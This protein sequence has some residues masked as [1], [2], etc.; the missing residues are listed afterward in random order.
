MCP[1]IATLLRVPVDDASAPSEAPKPV[2]ELLDELQQE[3]EQRRVELRE[4]AAL[5]PAAMSRRAILRAVAADFRHAP[6]KGDVVIRALRKLGRGPRFVA[7]W[8]KR[9]VMTT[10]R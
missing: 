2:E 5:L 1:R 9:T 3:S 6:D 8:L 10:A 4:I 7:G